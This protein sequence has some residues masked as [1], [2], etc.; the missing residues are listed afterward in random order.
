VKVLVSAA[1]PD[2]IASRRPGKSIALAQGP[3]LAN[4]KLPWPDSTLDPLS[5]QPQAMEVAQDD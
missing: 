4:A 2:R 3:A 1:L 5:K